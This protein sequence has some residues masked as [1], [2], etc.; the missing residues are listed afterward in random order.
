VDDGTPGEVL[1]VTSDP[2]DP[3]AFY[4]AGWQN[5]VAVLR[6]SHDGGK[7]WSEAD[8]ERNFAPDDDGIAYAAHVTASGRVAW[9]GY[10]FDG[11]G[12]LGPFL[13]VA[14]RGG[15]FRNIAMAVYMVNALTS[16]ETATGTDLL[17]MSSQPAGDPERL[18]TWRVPLD[19][20]DDCGGA[21][22]TG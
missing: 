4:A 5:K 8:S 11:P 7:T 13:R 16:L 20:G 6:A 2:S 14:D 12:W 9:G 1:E 19:G 3:S 22:G 17:V 10:R 15:A 21:G 18:A